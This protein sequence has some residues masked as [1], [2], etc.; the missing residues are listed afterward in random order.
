MLIAIWIYMIFYKYKYC[1]IKAHWG[2]LGLMV[3]NAIMLLLYAIRGHTC[4]IVH[5]P[6]VESILKLA[7][8]IIFETF[9]TTSLALLAMGFPLVVDS[10][11]CNYIARIVAVMIITYLGSSLV[12]IFGNAFPVLV[13]GIRI[14][15]FIYYIGLSLTVAWSVLTN[16]ATINRVIESTTY[17]PEIR[18]SFQLKRKPYLTFGTITAAYFF[19][20]ALCELVTLRFA[21]EFAA[22]QNIK[23]LKRL[24]VSLLLWVAAAMHQPKH[25]TEHMSVGIEV[26]VVPL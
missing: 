4:T 10:L 24:L 18:D 14:G 9:S 11:S 23:A 17:I 26:I 3:V 21:P 19:Y 2:L 22:L 6:V 25:F 20:M 13:P 15:F 7:F 1:T 5:D 8:T 12:N 16:M